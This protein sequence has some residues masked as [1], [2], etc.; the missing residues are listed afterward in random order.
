MP[1][2]RKR[3]KEKEKE[4]D[5]PVAVKMKYRKTIHPLIILEDRDRDDEP[6]LIVD[7]HYSIST[8][9]K[10]IPIF[11]C[12]GPG[13]TGQDLSD[14]STSDVLLEKIEDLDNTAPEKM[15]EIPPTRNLRKRKAEKIESI[16]GTKR[17]RRGP[18]SGPRYNFRPR[19]SRR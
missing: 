5:Q 7:A 14:S 8:E 11:L 4:E 18:A 19:P 15:P 12:E 1:R 6:D 16:N 9:I 13:A 2:K 17:E 3:E 10:E